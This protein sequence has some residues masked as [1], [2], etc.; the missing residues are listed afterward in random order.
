MVYDVTM[1][2]PLIEQYKSGKLPHA[3]LL[4]VSVESGKAL[5][6]GLA[7]EL[8][9][10]AADYIFLNSNDTKGSI[11]VLEI[12]QITH[13]AQL[14]RG[15]GAIKLAYIADAANLTTEAANAFLKTLEEPPA[16]THFILASNR[17]EA[18]LPTI[19]SRCTFLS[20][21]S[22]NEEKFVGKAIPTFVSLF[23]AF[24]YS[25]ELAASDTPLPEILSSWLAA[26]TA[27]YVSP[28]PKQ[29]ATA[30]LILEYL[31]KLESN[32]NRRLFLDNLLLD[33]YNINQLADHPTSR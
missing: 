1:I 27:Q 21:P 11:K 19:R 12:R 13:F 22:S 25:K 18:V 3:L 26:I 29:Q 16:G 32:P 4:E 5:A 24:N 20:L 23:E 17:V 7:T 33:L 2:N 10:T 28:T 9:L 30:A 15:G 6:D 14:S 8:S 31:P